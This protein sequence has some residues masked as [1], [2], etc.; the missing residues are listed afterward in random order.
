MS[1]LPLNP[2]KGLWVKKP[3]S[4]VSIEKHRHLLFIYIYLFVKGNSKKELNVKQ[5]C[6]TIYG[7]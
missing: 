6:Y 7:I 2:V 1:T 4:R 3:R 5:T